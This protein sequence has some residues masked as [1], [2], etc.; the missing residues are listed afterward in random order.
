MKLRI[1][2]TQYPMRRWLVLGLFICGMSVLLARV[3]YLQLLNNDF[4]KQ[5]GDARS[6]RVVKIPTHRGVINDRN[7]DQLAMST[8]VQSVWAVPRKALQA[9]PEQLSALAKVLNT[10]SKDLRQT[11]SA[12][13][14]RDFVYL[15]RHADPDIVEKIQQLN[16]PGVATQREYKR[17]YPAAEVTSHIIGFTNIDDQGQEG[18]ELAYDEWLSGKPGK[19]RVLK[20]RLN[21]VIK[22]IE[23]IESAA[24]G[25]ELVLSIDQRVQYLAYRELAAAVKRNKAKSGALVMLDVRTGE[26][27]ALV[28]QPSYNPNNRSN[29]KSHVYRNRIIADVFEPGSTMKPFVVA[30]GLM[31]GR[32]QP[33]TPIDTNPGY[34]KLGEQTIR[35]LRNYGTIDVETV[36]TKSS[37]VG[38]SKIAL[39]LEPQQYW[40]VL[41][42]F[43]FGQATSSGFP[44][45]AS[46]VLSSYNSWSDFEIA[47][48]SFGY[49]LSVTML[50]LAQAYSVFATDGIMLPI[51]FLKVTKPVAGKRIIPAKI[52]QQIRKML[53]TVVSSKGS[54]RRAGI[55]GYRV[56]GKT[57]TVH[58]FSQGGYYDN[59]YLS[60]FAGIAPA[61][62]PR[63]VIVVLINEP[64]QDSYYGGLVAAP[65]FSK[66]MEGTFRI[67]NVAPDDLPKFNNPIVA[68]S[69]KSE[70]LQA[71]VE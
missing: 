38:A 52:A 13:M 31:S 30:A 28:G 24:P 53:E 48:F 18:L 69:V 41:S 62:D 44:G 40:N 63:F 67:F 71:R 26:V 7:G 27:M 43:G 35:D 37:N 25:K 23:S 57:G 29:L 16:I 10:P 6:I 46:G 15:K 56:I 54:G 65:V 2:E 42:K 45:E 59:R 33:H 20:D 14:N 9:E 21:R 51:S 11:L 66:V 60:I 1:I 36:I 39:S 3:V 5:H 50:Q 17:Y 64:S 47:T 70:P 4:L 49:G 61:S 68:N 55:T 12:R 19:K 22:N 8:P 32:Y 34:F 58:K